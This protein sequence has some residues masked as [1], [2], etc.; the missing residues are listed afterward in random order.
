MSKLS[1]TSRC[2]FSLGHSRVEGLL[3]TAA[4]SRAGY[5]ER[6]GV[7]ALVLLSVREQ[8]VCLVLPPDIQGPVVLKED[9]L[10]GVY[11]GHM[12]LL[13]PIAGEYYCHMIRLL[14][15]SANHNTYGVVLQSI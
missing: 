15:G 5:K 7:R 4:T 11:K 9:G 12:T 14:T 6:A 3:S 13:E 10:E 2:L 1:L 8:A